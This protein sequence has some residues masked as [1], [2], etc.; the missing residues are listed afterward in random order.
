MVNPRNPRDINIPFPWI[1]GLE[2][3]TQEQ[4]YMDFLALG[5]AGGTR[6]RTIVIA[7]SNTINPSGADYECTGSGDEKI[8]NAAIVALE[9]KASSANLGRIV[10]LEGQY[11]LGATITISALTS[12][13]L[14]I[15]GMGGTAQS[16]LGVP[17][18]RLIGSGDFPIFTTN[19][20]GGDPSGTLILEN[21]AL[22]AASTVAAIST[23]DMTLHVRNCRIVNTGVSGAG[24]AQ[25]NST[26]GSSNTIIDG[27]YVVAGTGGTGIF[28]AAGPTRGTMSYVRNNTVNIS[29]AGTGIATGNDLSSIPS[30][31]INDNTIYGGGAASSVGISLHGTS[32]QNNVVCDNFIRN[33]AVG[34]QIAGYK[35]IVANNLLEICQTGISDGAFQLDA[36]FIVGN[37]IIDSSAVGISVGTQNCIKVGILGNKIVGYNLTVPVGIKVLGNATGTHVYYNDYDS[38]VTS[39]VVDTGTGTISQFGIPSGGTIGQLLT[40]NSSGAGDVSWQTD[41]VVAA[42]TAVGDLLVGTGAGAFTMLHKSSAMPSGDTYSARILMDDPASP[43]VKWGPTLT[44][45][46]GIAPT[47]P[48]PGDIWLDTT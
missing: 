32:T 16:D 43:G 48:Q 22:D 14:A 36:T 26:G 46:K 1:D 45:S 23:R 12:R 42:I 11:N 33:V 25:L 10:L 15:E 9:A 19:G 20:V 34:I 18:T 8:I 38:G 3:R 21:M 6:W 28:I 41:P 29:G 37:N 4:L 5:R 47:T 7:A 17:A 40:K 24:I 13:Q 27:N 30:Y 35:N 31:H 44:V 2:R 39:G